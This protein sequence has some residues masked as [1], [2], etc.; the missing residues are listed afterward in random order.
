MITSLNLL[1]C[2]IDSLGSVWELPA[3]RNY[4]PVL[5]LIKIVLPNIIIIIMLLMIGEGKEQNVK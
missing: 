4:L 1:H 3:Y 5:G 2:S